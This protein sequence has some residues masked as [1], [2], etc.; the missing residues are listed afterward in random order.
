MPKMPSVNSA[1]QSLLSV[2]A[3]SPMAMAT[4]MLEEGTELYA[5]NLRKRSK[6]MT[7]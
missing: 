7:S 1:D 5:K 2:P 4:A 6:F 3:F